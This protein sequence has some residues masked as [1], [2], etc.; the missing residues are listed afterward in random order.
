MSV[1]SGMVSYLHCYTSHICS[2]QSAPSSPAYHVL[3]YNCTNIVTC[4]EVVVR[5][6]CGSSKYGNYLAVA[7]NHTI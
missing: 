3:F 4:K 2:F 1:L 6:A 7:P 5:K